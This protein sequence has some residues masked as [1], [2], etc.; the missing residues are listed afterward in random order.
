M[1]NIIGQ[2]AD[3]LQAAVA[4]HQTLGMLDGSHGGVNGLLDF[5]ANL[6][7]RLVDRVLLTRL[8]ADHCDSYVLFLDGAV[9]L[10]DFSFGWRLAEGLNLVSDDGCYLALA[11]GDFNEWV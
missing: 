3:M 5:L 9:L 4:D 8:Q 7:D 2:L 1:R 11:V 10:L 6:L